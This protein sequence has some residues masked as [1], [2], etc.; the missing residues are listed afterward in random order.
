VRLGRGGL[1]IMNRGLEA[2]AGIREGE[3]LA[4]KYRVERVLGAGGMGVV[5]AAHHVQLDERVALKFLLPEALDNPDAVSRFAREARAAVKI[6]SEHVARVTDVG[7]LPN[8]APFMVMEYLEGGDLG[9]WLKQRGALPIEQAVEFVLQACVA[10][11]DA[12]A[13]G[14]VHRDLK[15]AN[16]FCVRRSDGQLSIKVLDFGISKMTDR[17]GVAAGAATGT[18]AL[19]GSPL[20]MSPEQMRSARDVDGKTDIWALG[21]IL[22]E[23]ITGR[24]VFQGQSVTELAVMVTNEPA[25]SIRSVRPD[26]P[27]GLEA[28][29][30]K[31][32]EKDRQR[33]YRNVAELA[34][35]LLEFGPKRAKA[36]V[37]RITG[38]VQ[39]AG[40]SE[41]AL[42]LPPSPQPIRGT[43]LA[44]EPETVIPVGRT[45][46]TG[47]TRRKAV[48]W[49][50][51]GAVALVAAVGS[52]LGLTR[53]WRHQDHPQAVAPQAVAP[54]AVGSPSVKPMVSKPLPSVEPPKPDDTA[55]VNEVRVDALPAAPKPSAAAAAPSPPAEAMTRRRQPPSTPAAS[56]T[57]GPK[58]PVAVALPVAPVSPASAIHCD[59]PYFFDAKGNRVFKPECL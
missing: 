3:V 59:P 35:A 54:Q 15:P 49:R 26:V 58:P 20:Y 27:I 7:T 4:G 36:S 44:P 45:A 30:F 23:L 46:T 33:R 19:M 14:I 57:P 17:S 25:P 1:G 8:G 56:A 39:S 51:V 16:L 13:L 2:A 38:I 11:A 24:P 40:L 32:L 52:A 6:K 5:V 55:A 31:C 48:V 9:A 29:I 37:E 42:A 43:L 41:S 53:G 28:I 22:F 47:P 18:S 50:L 12:H 21:V 34:V 10:V